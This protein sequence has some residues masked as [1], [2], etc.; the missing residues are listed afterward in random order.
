M[1][2]AWRA[3]LMMAVCVTAVTARERADARMPPIDLKHQI[4]TDAAAF[5]AEVHR[6][7][8]VAVY[9]ITFGRGNATMQAGSEAALRE[10][11][12][13]MKERTDWRFEVQ[14][15]TDNVGAPAANRALSLRRAAV[16]VEWLT[17]NGIDV[18]RLVAKGYGDTEPV[19]DNATGDGRAK[20][21]RIELKKLHEE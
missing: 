18:S 14:A 4:T 10:I 11:V 1:N 9:G 13:L 2:R 20:N 19:A 3:L 5:E 16:V 12:E 6:I 8:S 7:G 17:K 15:H 21:C